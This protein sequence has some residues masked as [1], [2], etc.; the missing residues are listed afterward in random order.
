[1]G[2][3]LLS[4]G[5]N[6]QRQ[7][8]RVA[9]CVWHARS[10]CSFLL[11]FSFS[12]LSWTHA[13]A[14][15]ATEFSATTPSPTPESI[16]FQEIP[17]VYGASKYEQ[18]VTEAP[19]SV[20]IITADEIKKY[21]YRT[22]NDV[23][24]SVTGLY[25]TNDRNYSYLGIRGFNRPGDYNTRVLLLIDGHR[26]NDNVYD[27]ALY[28]TEGPIDVDLIDRVEIIRGPSSS[29]YGTNAFFGVINVITKRGRDIKGLELSTE[30]GS[31]DSYLARVTYGNRFQNGMELF[32]SG[33]WYDSQGHS[34]LFYPEFDD[35]TT[36]NGIIRNADE[37]QYYHLFGKLALG[38][39]TLEG[40][41]RYRTKHVPTAPF[42]TI[43]NTRRTRTADERSFIDLKYEREFAK[44]WDIMVRLYYDHYHY[45]GNYLYDYSADGGPP[46]V[47]NQDLLLGNWWGGEIKVTKRFLDRHRLTVGAEL[48]DN[49]HQDQKNFDTDPF[50]SYFK[51]ERSSRNWAFYLQDEFS[52]LRNLI[53]NVGFRYDHYDSFG[54]TVNPRLA[55]IYNLPK[56]TFKIL[57]GEA[58][59][60]PN[61]FERFYKS[62][63]FKPNP[64]LDPEEIKTYELVV[65][66]YLGNHL[67]ASVA[68][69]YYTISGLISQV[70]DPVDDV[71]AFQNAE[72]LEAK[73]LE[74]E[75]DGNWAYGLE[76]RLS[77]AIQEAKNQA[78]G[79]RLTNSPQHMVKLNLIV[80]LI[81]EQ[82]FAGLEARYL[83]ERLTQCQRD[84]LDSECLRNTNAFFVT[85]LT[86]FSQNLIKGVEVSGS[87]YNLF[88]EPY[89]D[90]GSGEHIQE[91]IEQD[92]RTF[93]LKLK[94]AF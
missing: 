91:V 22:I 84:I 4:I 90:P 12:F 54:S 7:N 37:D 5:E 61:M 49:L 46:R 94:Y 53:L 39:F 70:R 28:G 80:P 78:T 51:D 8:R 79:K 63:T 19:S 48:R 92:G 34:S 17:S 38:D 50:Y 18:K 47:L 13:H 10:L 68:G 71:L 41:H 23:L 82:I 55:L 86:L 11:I 25:V 45:R 35:S 29:L 73:G 66:R 31:Y 72:D 93:W 6:N 56:T 89:G 14:E 24:Q 85:N 83:S 26:M 42:G 1:M 75:L 21:G 58:F 76:G 43:F 30:I 33:S 67:R 20:T 88:D 2:Y 69:Y 16:L 36:N 74:L 62:G 27:E 87:I 64:D 65:E 77:Y 81:Q 3:E 59:R 60:A 15:T 44:Y 9:V 57:Y 40:A 52:L 32:L